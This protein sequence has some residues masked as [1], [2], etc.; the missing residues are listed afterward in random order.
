MLAG[1]YCGKTLPGPIK[2]SAQ[3]LYIVFHSDELGAFKGFKAEWSSTPVTKS[4]AKGNLQFTVY[5]D[6]S[7]IKDLSASGDQ[8]NN[9]QGQEIEISER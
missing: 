4:A 2:A 3:S 6:I 1:K 5:T 8:T 9:E 7:H